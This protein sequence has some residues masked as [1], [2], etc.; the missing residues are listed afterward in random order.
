MQMKYLKTFLKLGGDIVSGV[1]NITASSAV[2]DDL[3]KRLGPSGVNEILLTLWQGYYDLLSDAR[4]II[5]ESTP[6]DDITQEWYGKIYL[7]WTSENRAAILQINNIGPVH[8]H[9]DSTFT[10]GYGKKNT[11]DFCFRDWDTSNS[12][13]GAE[14]KNLYH[15]R[16]DKIKRYV[17]TGVKHYISGKYGSQSSESS[18]VGYVLSGEISEIVAELISEISKTGPTSNLSREFRYVEPQYASQ[19][20][21][22]FDKQEITIHH[23]FFDFCHSST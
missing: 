15:K 19:H 7:R 12:Y 22:D 20:T 3:A 1:R 13:F 6:E 9:Q 2:P 17:D 8:Q 14:C 4:I 10:K 18:I 5:T 23:L 16:K 21:R 11:I